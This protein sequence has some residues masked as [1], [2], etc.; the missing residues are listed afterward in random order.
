MARRRVMTPLR[1]SDMDAYG[2]VNNVQFL[3]LM[4]DARVIAFHGH[5]ADDGGDLLSTG[6]IVARH[7]IDYLVPL[8]YRPAP[9]AID[10][11]ISSVAGASF[12][13]CYEVLD[14]SDDE[15]AAPVVYARAESTMVAY[16]LDK[17][18]PKRIGPGDREKFRQWW[19]EPVALRSRQR[20]AR[21]EAPQ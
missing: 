12:E 10:L 21:V 14:D 7:E 13:M 2:H 11:W 16:D 17:L 8:H 5:D 20:A 18:R 9:V 15:G 1:W 19:D 3:R 4:E 6:L